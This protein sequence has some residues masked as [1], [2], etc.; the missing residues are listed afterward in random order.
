[1]EAR[2]LQR[3]FKSPHGLPCFTRDRGSSGNQGGKTLLHCWPEVITCLT[4]HSRGQQ[5]AS[6]RFPSIPFR[7]TPPERA[8]QL[9]SARSIDARMD[10]RS[11]DYL[12]ARI[13]IQL[14]RMSLMT[15]VSFP[16]AR[17]LTGVENNLS[18]HGSNVPRCSARLQFRL[19]GS[20]ADQRG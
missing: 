19:P 16:C 20:V 9:Q 12:L 17:H 4:C 1:M 11:A 7:T 10:R 3:R 14:L 15:T 2:R 8:L 5:I 18:A 6:Q 13:D